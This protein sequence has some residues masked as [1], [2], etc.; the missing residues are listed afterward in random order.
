MDV[1]TSAGRYR[2]AMERI[3][4][5]IREPVKPVDVVVAIGLA[6]LSMAALVGGAPDV[7]PREPVTVVLLLLQ[8]LPLIARR[9][10]PLEVML[11]VVSATIVQIAL[12]PAGG[13]LQAGLGVLVAVYTIGERLERR[14][15][16]ALTVLAGAILGVLI[17]ALGGLPAALQGLIQTELII[18]VAWLIGDASRIRRLYTET[19][20]ERT[21]PIERERDERTRRAI[22]EERGRISREL[23]DIV[24]HHVSVMVIQAGGGVRAL[25]KRPDEARTAF[26]AIAATGRQ[27]LADMRRMLGILG[28]GAAPEPMPGLDRL[29]DLLEQ[30]RSAGL[31]VAV[32]VEGERRR[33]DPGL[34]LTAYRIIQEGLTNSLKHSGGEA[35]LLIAFSPAELGIT[36]DDERAPTPAA[37]VEPTHE[38]RGL[39][40][41]RERVA[42]FG[43]S[44]AAEP[45]ASGFRVTT[46]LP[47]IDA[48][49]PP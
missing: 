25:D 49:A 38:G 29:D 28:D 3:G 31:E 39:V 7:G 22:L 6:G 26:E 42:V 5:P 11:T 37:P 21:A 15:S 47:I 23:H 32:T 19:L 48:G 30:V 14:T 20:E 35:R 17:A 40:G 36:I 45:T 1:A 43:G 16:L 27:A 4:D 46:R 8:S 34:E 12:V 9:P 2:S 24:T 33:L 44:F 10:F 18:G 41:M 13:Q